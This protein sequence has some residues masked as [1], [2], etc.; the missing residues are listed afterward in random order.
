[1][2]GIF[3]NLLSAAGRNMVMVSWTKSRG[4]PL[5]LLSYR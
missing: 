4:S 2:Y 5:S 1:M 3:Y